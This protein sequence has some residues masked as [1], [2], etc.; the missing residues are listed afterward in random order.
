M[1]CKLQGGVTGGCDDQLQIKG[2]Q[3]SFQ[4]Q[5]SVLTPLLVNCYHHHLD[6]YGF[7]SRKMALFGPPCP[8]Y[9]LHRHGA[10][11]SWKQMRRGGRDQLAVRWCFIQGGVACDLKLLGCG[12]RHFHANI[13]LVRF[14]RTLRCEAKPPIR[15][16][17]GPLHN[18]ALEQM[19]TGDKKDGQ[20]NQRELVYW[21][22]IYMY[23]KSQRKFV[24]GINPSHKVRCECN[25]GSGVGTLN[26]RERSLKYC[27]SGNS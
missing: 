7:F 8:H 10:G 12:A 18:I 24:A 4:N 27:L 25:L 26:V 23:T 14:C 6:C 15:Q 16:P 22:I 5:C 11:I 2:S 21:G 1:R 9:R 3:C 17:P 19:T 20:C 13:I